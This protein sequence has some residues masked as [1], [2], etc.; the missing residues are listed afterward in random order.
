MLMRR[1]GTADAY[2]PPES[3]ASTGGHHSFR[4]SDDWCA[5]VWQPATGASSRVGV[6]CPSIA[7]EH[8]RGRPHDRALA[9]RLAARGVS[10]LRFDYPATGSSTGSAI[11]AEGEDADL[12]ARWS[13]SI[14]LAD[15][16]REARYRTL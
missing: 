5:A 3:A 12:A 8:L 14:V 2:V 1:E 9:R 11:V 4:S 13:A 16:A 7:Q 6:L 15:S 10:S